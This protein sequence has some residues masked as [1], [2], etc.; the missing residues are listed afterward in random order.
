MNIDIETCQDLAKF[1]FITIEENISFVATAR[2]PVVPSRHA[3]P[4][5]LGKKWLILSACTFLRETSSSL[6]VNSQDRAR[7][8][9]RRVSARFVHIKKR[10]L[11]NKYDKSNFSP[12]LTNNVTTVRRLT[13]RLVRIV[14]YYLFLLL[15]L[16]YEGW[17]AGPADIP[18]PSTCFHQRSG[19]V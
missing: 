3:M 10:I 4:T 12:S 7:Y 15:R 5:H 11:S 16:R 9:R 1:K 8:N 18:I 13:A 19:I 14:M 2:R 6:L 17:S